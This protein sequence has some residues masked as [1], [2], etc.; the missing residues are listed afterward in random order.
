[1]DI[2]HHINL[3]PY[4][5]F[6]FNST[7]DRFVEINSEDQIVDLVRQGAFAETP[8]F[9][10]GGGSNVLFKSHVE[11]LVVHP[12]MSGI[13]VAGIQNDHVIVEAMAG[14]E[15]DE[16]VAFCVA[17]GFHG[18]ENLSMIP[19]NVGASPVQ[20]IG[21]YGVEVCDVID[22]VFG[23]DLQNGTRLEF[24]AGE[25][26]FKYRDSIFKNALKKRVI[27]TKVQ[28]RLSLRP[29]YRLEYGLVSQ[30]VEM[31]GGPSLQNVRD[32]IVGIRRSKLPDPSE[33]G[34]AGSFF[35]NPVIEK[36]LA[37]QIKQQYPQMPGY[38]V[39]DGWVKIPAGWLI[40]N[41]GW[42]GKAMGQAAVHQHQALVLVNLGNATCEEVLT[43]ADAIAGDVE[44]CFGICLEKEVNVVG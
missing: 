33:F 27:I 15:W 22:K 30:A 40:E 6:G 36:S 38:H 35:K 29:E 4:H 5:T 13:N 11:G 43:L 18:I 19:G 44:R 21:A 20:N 24:S 3:K 9:V 26:G 7:A 12:T 31:L 17:N 34:N 10:L 42:K 14:V 8:F 16:L 41:C 23:I 28:Y 32:A 37:G 39:N 25:C 1:M 2:L